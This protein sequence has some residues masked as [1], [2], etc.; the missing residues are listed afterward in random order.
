L[1]ELVDWFKRL[2][3]A[4]KVTLIYLVIGSFFILVFFNITDFLPVERNYLL[5]NLILIALFRLYFSA[6]VF[7][8]ILRYVGIKNELFYNKLLNTEKK[9]NILFNITSVVKVLVDYKT[10]TIIDANEAAYKFFGIKRSEQKSNR[11]SDLFSDE[12]EF[13]YVK[14][15]INSHP[16]S[17]SIIIK[18]CTRKKEEKYL[19]IFLDFVDFTIDGLVYLTVHDVT[20]KHNLEKQNEEYKKN[21]EKLVR[22]RTTDLRKINI[23]LE[24]ENRRITFAEQRIEN[25]LNFFK[26]IMDTIPI[27]VFI[28]GIDGKF[29]ECNK[30]FCDY[31]ELEKKDIIGLTSYDIIPYDFAK[32]TEFYDDEIKRYLKG[33]RLERSFIGFDGQEHFIQY[34]KSPLLKTDGTIDGIVGIINDITEYRQLQLDIKKALEK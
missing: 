29:L 26:T 10:F 13:E 12:T 14:N 25:Q 34:K 27:P 8:L 30:S 11:M 18:F 16:Q 28:K 24:K 32:E 3:F 31:F 4:K 6:V 7:Y 1:K 17:G 5:N 23:E 33:I 20:E 15:F 9:Y 21:L 2:D 22:E 19:E